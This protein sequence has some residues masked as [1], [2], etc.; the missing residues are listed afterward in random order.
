MY[1]YRWCNTLRQSGQ[2]PRAC[3]KHNRVFDDGGRECLSAAT[4]ANIDWLEESVY[5]GARCAHQSRT[6]VLLGSASASASKLPLVAAPGACK[7]GNEMNMNRPGLA[8]HPDPRVHRAFT[9]AF[10]GSASL[11]YTIRTRTRARRQSRTGIDSE[12][13]SKAMHTTISTTK[14][15]FWRGLIAGMLQG[16]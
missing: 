4:V 2:Q 16:Q 8:Q 3:K 6:G 11:P 10:G 5:T 7:L 9:V 12:G 13:C 14:P 1:L 15:E